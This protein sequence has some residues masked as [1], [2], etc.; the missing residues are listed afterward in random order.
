[1]RRYKGEVEGLSF[2]K[3]F[4]LEY[5][6]KREKAFV[7]RRGEYVKKKRKVLYIIGCFVFVVL[8]IKSCEVSTKSSFVGMLK[9]M[10]QEVISDCSLSIYKDQSSYQAYIIDRTVPPEIKDCNVVF[11]FMTSMYPIQLYLIDK[12]INQ[13]MS[14]ELEV[15]N[16]DLLAVMKMMSNSKNAHLF[17]PNDEDHAL[18][19]E[20]ELLKE[21]NLSRLEGNPRDTYYENPP[22]K[23]T[24]TVINNQA[25]MKKVKELLVS[26]SYAYLI[27]NFYIV[28]KTT[29][30]TE[31]EFDVPYLLGKDFTI[32]K[33]TKGPQILIFHTHASEEFVDSRKDN[34]NDTVVGVGEHLK[35]ILESKYGYHVLH[36][37]SVYDKMGG[38]LDRSKAYDYAYKGVSK[39]LKE[40]PTISVIIDLHRNEGNRVV[41]NING[42]DTAPI[43]LFNGLSRNVKGDIPYVKNNNLKNNLAFS[44]QLELEGMKKYKDLMKPIYLKSWRY[45]LHLRERA[46]LVELGSQKNTKQEAMNAME[47]FAEILDNV[48]SRNRE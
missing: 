27:K 12:R 41:T 38:Y 43:M 32:K 14:G 21:F 44:L 29:Y 17:A 2:H 39:I 33:N 28:D 24:N 22:V 3:S 31:K 9:A 7:S 15:L 6:I 18:L 36:D 45:N 26:K 37:T 10:A 25:N 46:L 35:D 42:K 1:M 13:V 4:A 20:E 8:V 16:E 47:P 23:Q 11:H 34:Y 19:T 5:I 30:T 48:L 40:H